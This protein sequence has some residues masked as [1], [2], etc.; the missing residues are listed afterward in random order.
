MCDASFLQMG[1][2]DLAIEYLSK[3]RLFELSETLLPKIGKL[4]NEVN[5]F[6]EL[7]DITRCKRAMEWRKR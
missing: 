2:N 3:E 7:R 6:L 1:N 4:E 5:V